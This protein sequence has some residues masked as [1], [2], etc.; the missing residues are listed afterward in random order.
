MAAKAAQSPLVRRRKKMDAMLDFPLMIGID[1]QLLSYFA[2]PASV[3]PLLASAKR[4]S[5]A[6][7]L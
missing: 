6:G 3:N 2:A 1:P 7:S 4:K 5:L